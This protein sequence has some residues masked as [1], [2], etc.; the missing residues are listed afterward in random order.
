LF[1]HA[2]P[3]KLAPELPRGLAGVPAGIPPFAGFDLPAWS[4]ISR[5]P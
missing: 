2:L 1:G 4:R 5:T 3:V